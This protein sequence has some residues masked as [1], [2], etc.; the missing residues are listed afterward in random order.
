M[1]CTVTTCQKR[2]RIHDGHGNDTPGSCPETT[3]IVWGGL[4]VDLACTKRRRGGE[5]RNSVLIPFPG[6]ISKDHAPY[7]FKLRYNNRL[8]PHQPQKNAHPNTDKTQDYFKTWQRHCV[9]CLVYPG[10]SA[11]SASSPI[12]CCP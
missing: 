12:C 2:S 1:P 3:T 4:A 11:R 8:A 6:P 5:V 9:R 7:L 10:R